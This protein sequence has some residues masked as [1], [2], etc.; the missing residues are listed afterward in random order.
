[1]RPT[2]QEAGGLL[3][4]VP[5]GQQLQ[6]LALALAEFDAPLLRPRSPKEGADKP[7]REQRRDVGTALEHFCNG[8]Q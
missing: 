8:P 6:H 2:K 7:L 4:R 1:M 3:H 5:L